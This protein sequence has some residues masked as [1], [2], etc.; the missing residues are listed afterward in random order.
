MP[1]RQVADARPDLLV[2]PGVDELVQRP[3]RPDHPERAVLGVDQRDR[4]RHDPA[5]RGRQLQATGDTD[6]RVEQAVQLVPAGRDLGQPV[7]HLVQQLVQPQRGQPAA[8]PLGRGGGGLACPRLH[9]HLPVRTP[10]RPMLAHG[11]VP[12][13][14]AGT[15]GPDS[16]PSARPGGRPAPPAGTPAGVPSSRPA[17]RGPG[18][19]SGRARRTGGSSPGARRCGR[20]RR[21]P[22]GGWS[23]L[24]AGAGLAGAHPP[25][26]DAE[27]AVPLGGGQ[28]PG[29]QAG[30]ASGSRT[31][32]T[33]R[34]PDRWRRPN[35]GSAS[36]PSRA[37]YRCRSQ[38][39]QLGGPQWTVGRRP[40]AGRSRRPRSP[41]CRAG[42]GRW[43]A[44]GSRC[45]GAAG[46]PCTS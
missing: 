7:G 44:P 26:D 23:R 27:V 33:S 16:G 8:Q 37:P 3:V 12:V 11:P 10:T 9:G 28:A 13:G 2:D 38:G 5:Q 36:S 43:A 25:G 39:G 46:R 18:R 32:S 31:S 17:T 45:A 42:S 35:A 30:A 19:R 41:P 4:R 14:R 40:G 29:V 34:R 6:H 20:R 21:P 15:A 24:P 22:A 1:L